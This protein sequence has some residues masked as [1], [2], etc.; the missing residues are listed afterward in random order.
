MKKWEEKEKDYNV[1][2][3]EV[4]K[5]IYTLFLKWLFFVIISGAHSEE[6][7]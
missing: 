1:T 4:T 2:I 5:Y 6:I 3:D 7:Y